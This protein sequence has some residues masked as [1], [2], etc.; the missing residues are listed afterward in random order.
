LLA[1]G[2]YTVTIA[3]NGLVTTFTIAVPTGTATMTLDQVVSSP[4]AYVFTPPNTVWNGT[5]AG[6][7]TFQ[8]IANPAAPTTA[9]A[10]SVGGHQTSA[11]SFA[12]QIAWQDAF[13]NLTFHSPDVDNTAPTGANNS[14]VLTLPAAVSG[15]AATLI[16]RSNADST[17]NRYFL[18]QVAANV[19]TYTDWQSAS[20]F[21]GTMNPANKAPLYNGTA[22]AILTTNGTVVCNLADQ[23]LYVPN[24]NLRIVPGFGLQLYNYDTNLWHTLLCSGNPARI[25]L[26]AGQL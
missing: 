22:G 1:A 15:V 14:T 9:A 4:L 17:T 3:V 25:S 2:N 11:S 21:A 13:G 7:I 12:Y 6:Q 23:G 18:A 19:T 24:S 10:N 8:P 5:R 20:D 16:Y 26:D